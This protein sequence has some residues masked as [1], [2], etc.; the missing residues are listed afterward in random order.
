VTDTAHPEKPSG[1]KRR[2]YALIGV[3]LVGVLWIIFSGTS[4][5]SGGLCDS[6]ADCVSEADQQA[7]EP[8]TVERLQQVVK[9]YQYACAHYP[10]GD[11]C[12]RERVSRMNLQMYFP[13]AAAP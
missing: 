2:R 6:A 4:G 7:S 1:S 11:S 13:G 3:A 5:S 12:Q 8:H 9:I 10:E